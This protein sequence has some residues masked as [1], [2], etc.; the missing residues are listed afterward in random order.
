MDTVAVPGGRADRS[1][2]PGRTDR[3]AVPAGGAD[4]S[5]VP[6]GGADRSAVATTGAS[7]GFSTTPCPLRVVAIAS[8]AISTWHWRVGHWALAVSRAVP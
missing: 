2:V 7:A 6:A 4:R 3:S 5:V 1:A 8:S